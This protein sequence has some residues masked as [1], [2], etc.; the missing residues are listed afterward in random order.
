MNP[1][2]ITVA[3]MLAFILLGAGAAA[4]GY[5]ITARRAFARTVHRTVLVNLDTG[6]AF[7]GVLTE[8]RPHLLV[9]RNATLL[10]AGQ[11]V[12]VDGEALV[13]LERVEFVQV[14]T[15]REVSA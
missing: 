15:P 8:Q 7:R 11:V 14:V 3:A 4:V 10:E 12:E 9:L 6:K 1:A 5:R 13:P 2:L